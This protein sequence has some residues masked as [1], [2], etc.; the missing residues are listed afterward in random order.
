M[1]INKRKEPIGIITGVT[2]RRETIKES[3][4]GDSQDNLA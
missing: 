2:K 4:L 3:Q 1:G